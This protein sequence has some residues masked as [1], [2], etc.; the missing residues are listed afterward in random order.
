[1]STFQC[2]L[3]E[4]S[5]PGTGAKLSRTR[6]E[7][8]GV[9]SPRPLL[10]LTLLHC[11]Y[12]SDSTDVRQHGASQPHVYPTPPCGLLTFVPS[13]CLATRVPTQPSSE[14]R[15]CG[16]GPSV[17]HVY[18]TVCQSDSP[19]LYC[20]VVIWAIPPSQ[21]LFL[22]LKTPRSPGRTQ[23]KVAVFCGGP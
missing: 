6:Q 13:D 15:G 10:T 16:Q 2:R 17:S 18:M 21:L 7:F 4:L 8:A 14:Q 9:R 23:A 20:F 22:K 11:F 5:L 3:W 19:S 12:Q 1:M